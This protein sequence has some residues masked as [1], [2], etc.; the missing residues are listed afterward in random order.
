V[1]AP[2][3]GPSLLARGG[4][5]PTPDRRRSRGWDPRRPAGLQRPAH[6]GRGHARPHSRRR[7]RHR[8]LHDGSRRARWLDEPRPSDACGQGLPS[9]IHALAARL[10]RPDAIDAEPPRLTVR[11]R[12]GRWAVLHASRLPTEAATAIGVISE[13][14][15]PSDLAAVLM[16]AH[17]L[18]LQEQALATL[19][20]RGLS[21]RQLADRL[22]NTPP[23]RPGASQGRFR[24]DR[25]AQP[26]RTRRSG[27]PA[28][29]PPAHRRR[30]T[31]AAW[32]PDA[33]PTPTAGS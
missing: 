8:R 33:R 29:L 25:R 12:S 4:P 23:H 16:K 5:L 28:A 15:P 27:P 19:I 32:R 6:G 14:P 7:G 1:P 18:T 20:C 2:R 11:T 31:S 30:R 26:T 21:T 9:E 17:G 3:V 13:E 22:H 10:R 24:Q